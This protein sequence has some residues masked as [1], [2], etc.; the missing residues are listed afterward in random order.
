MADF[1]LQIDST[2]SSSPQHSG[3][4]ARPVQ[5]HDIPPEVRL[6]IYRH[7]I[8][9]N[10]IVHID[11]PSACPKKY[12]DGFEGAFLGF[13]R[14]EWW[15]EGWGWIKSLDP[16]NLHWSKIN[17]T[18]KNGIFCVSKTIS[19]EALG[20]LY[21]ENI[22]E[23]DLMYYE[24]FIP[25]ETLSKALTRRIKKLKIVAHADE[26]I[27]YQNWILNQSLWATVFQDL[28]NF[29]FEVQTSD[30]PQDWYVGL[31]TWTSE[32]QEWHDSVWC[33]ELTSCFKYLQ[34]CEVMLT[35]E[36]SPDKRVGD[37]VEKSLPRGYRKFEGDTPG[38]GIFKWKLGFIEPGAIFGTSP[39]G[40]YLC[41]SGQIDG[42]GEDGVLEEV[43]G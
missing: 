37:F 6:K 34:G 28:T 42:E 3:P 13:R 41:G 14:R 26:K 15:D 1:E 25:F 24:R 40:D 32:K 43:Q 22:F 2:M 17:A 33:F 4:A 35:V 39:S 36:Q 11:L 27:S 30:R 21:G 10:E 7:F 23:V 29:Y 8:P 9:N 16:D 38:N 12:D 5:F 20:V 31:E 18:N 19:E